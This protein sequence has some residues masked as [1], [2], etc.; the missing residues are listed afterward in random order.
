MKP[1]GDNSFGVNV[2]KLRSLYHEDLSTAHE[3]IIDM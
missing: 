1:K 3:D 2:V